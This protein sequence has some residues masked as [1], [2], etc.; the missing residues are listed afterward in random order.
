MSQRMMM[1]G[2]GM[3]ISHSSNERM[4]SSLEVPGKITGL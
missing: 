1:I 3:P 4:K 2:S